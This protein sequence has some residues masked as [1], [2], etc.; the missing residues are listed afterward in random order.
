MRTILNR[1]FRL[2]LL[3]IGSLTLA[4]GLIAVGC[5]SDSGSDGGEPTVVASTTQVADLATNVAGDRAN[6]VGILAANS[7]P[8]DYEP[9]PSDAEALVDADLVLESGGDLD[10]W[11]G[12]LVESSGTD[13]PVVSL[14]DSVRTIAGGDDGSEETDPHWWQDPRNAIRAVN[15]VRDELITVDPKGRAAYM[16]N[17]RSYTAQIHQLDHRIASCVERV[18]SDERKL[19]TSHDALGYYADRYGIEVVGS[20]IPALT[21]QAQP[22]AGET[23]QLVDVIRSEHVNAVFPEIGVSAKLEQAI[24]DETGAAIGGELYAD[25]LGPTGSNGD[26]YL[27]ALAANTDT[28]VDGFT[29]GRIDCALAG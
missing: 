11:M 7:D 10:L 9:K 12:D 28:L 27:G 8:H 5:G 29:A 26:T 2:R 25:S 16:R 23:A 4:A 13:A 14:I 18:P 6:V 24:S 15:K 17:A 1:V 3:A 21:T 19:V 20:T 22:S